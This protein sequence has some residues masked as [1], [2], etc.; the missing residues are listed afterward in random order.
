M[1]VLRKQSVAEA[2]NQLH[3][4]RLRKSCMIP[5]SP[6]SS[7]A[8]NNVLFFL[9]CKTGLSIPNLHRFNECCFGQWIC[10]MDWML[11]RYIGW[12]N[13]D[14]KANHLPWPKKTYLCVHGL[15]QRKVKEMWRAFTRSCDYS[16]I[17]PWNRKLMMVSSQ[18]IDSTIATAK[19]RLQHAKRS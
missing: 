15:K 17:K 16:S 18:S 5:C 11:D 9:S 4:E 7:S 14:T 8:T 2:A 19:I 12:S 10:S 1:L 3:W 13:W 6:P